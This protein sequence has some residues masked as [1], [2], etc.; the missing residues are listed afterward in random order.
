M[1]KK[2]KAGLI[3][4][5]WFIFL[6]VLSCGPKQPAPK[7]AET[8]KE[9]IAQ[10]E[11]EKAVAESMPALKAEETKP[12]SGKERMVIKVKDYG[13]IKIE[14]FAKDA[15]KNVANIVKLVKSG[16]YDG[17]KFHR[18]IPNF[19][20]QGGDPKGDGTGGP[21][22]TIEAEIKPGLKHLKGSVAM[23]RLPDQINPSRASSGSQF[24]IC[25]A[26]VP[27]L[28]GQYTIIGKVVDGLGVVD[29]IGKVQT[30]SGDMPVKDVIMEKV[31][32]EE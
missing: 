29:A 18:V 23:A 22:Y 8:P 25:L 17:L 7:A 3:F 5:L 6:L 2:I 10:T 19:V 27:H 31:T 21:G 9:E 16:F 24:Y 20:A 15:P 30:G 32:I 4:G 26:P 28:D 13:T 12:L 14:L 1:H 11:P